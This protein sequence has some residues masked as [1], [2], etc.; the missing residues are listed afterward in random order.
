MG[1]AFWVSSVGEGV[2]QMN[3]AAK[4]V[5]PR[6]TCQLGAIPVA[7]PAKAIAYPIISGASV[8]KMNQYEAA[9]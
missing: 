4:L 8:R 6:C 2:D 9:S 7:T 5:V 3:F 1:V